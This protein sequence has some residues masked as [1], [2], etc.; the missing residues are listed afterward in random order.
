MKEN[1]KYYFTVEGET[2]Q[3]YLQWLQN[4]VNAE[5]TSKYRRISID[6]PIQ[7]DP[8]KRAKSLVTLG[9]TEITHMFDYESNDEIHTTQF[10]TTMDRMKQSQSLGKSIKY[11]LGYSNFTFELW[12][13]LHKTDCNG[14]L[15]HRKQYITFINIAYEENFENLD[16]YKHEDN[17]KR[18]LS[19]LTLDDVKNAIQRSKSIM[20]RNQDK[21]LVLQQ[22]KGYRYYKENPS[23][24]IWEVIE[25]ILLDCGLFE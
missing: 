1:R 8:L 2:E 18:V 23:L 21:G 7:K 13:V 24:S 10:H 15:N 14:C 16:Q 22:Y 5:P 20:Q 17:F 9:K 11:Q 19:K 12:M 6:C 4:T 3:W 25:K